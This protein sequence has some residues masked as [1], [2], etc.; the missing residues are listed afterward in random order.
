MQEQQLSLNGSVR[1]AMNRQLIF[2]MNGEVMD[3]YMKIHGY[4]TLAE[5][6]LDFKKLPAMTETS[7]VAKDVMDSVE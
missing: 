4:T 1:V 6:Y 7:E 3:S 2:V 5:I